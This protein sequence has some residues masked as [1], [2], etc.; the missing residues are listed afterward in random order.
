VDETRKCPF[1]GEEILA[2][3]VK[4]K[5]CHEWLESGHKEEGKTADVVATQQTGKIYKGTMLFGGLLVIV[6]SIVVG[7]AEGENSPATPIGGAT[8]FFGLVIVLVGA[9][10]AW[11]RHG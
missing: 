3:A 7:S 10:G 11:W 8:F 9:I 5:H 1:C 2:S 4:C 6:G